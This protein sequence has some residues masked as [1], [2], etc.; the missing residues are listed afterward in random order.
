M[1]DELRE[2]GRNAL[3]DEFKNV[4]DKALFFERET[5]DCRTPE[6]LAMQKKLP[7]LEFQLWLIR[8]DPVETEKHWHYRRIWAEEHKAEY[9]KMTKAERKKY[10]QK[11]IRNDSWTRRMIRESSRPNKEV[12]KRQLQQ[13]VID[14]SDNRQ[15]RAWVPRWLP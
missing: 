10:R 4:R 7:G 3:R 1:V 12:F 6:E 5:A 8:D 14:D 13:R 15:R 11:F 9:G 2:I